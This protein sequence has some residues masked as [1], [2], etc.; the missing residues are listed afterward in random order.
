MTTIQDIYIGAERL[1]NLILR[2][3]IIA[4]GHHLTGA[5]E[6]SLKSD[7]FKEGKTE[8]MEGVAL[9]YSQFVEHGFPA[10]SASM[11]QWPF[12]YR[13][14]L[15][16]GFSDQDAKRV[17]AATIRKWMSQTGMPTLGSKAYSQTGSRTNYVENAMI[18][19]EPKIDEYMT[20]SLDFVVEERF[21]LEKSETI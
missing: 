21:Q 16:R 6:D 3:E 11:K 14:F 13:Y 4:Q 20:N 8:V 10:A 1:I 7:I 18:G 17:A 2:E 9:Y 12:V 15:Q 19:A 5:L